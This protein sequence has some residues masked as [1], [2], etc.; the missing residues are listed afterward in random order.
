M[1]SRYSRPKAYVIF[2]DSDKPAPGYPGEEGKEDGVDA[3]IL[4]S[5]TPKIAGN[6]RPR[7]PH[8]TF[9]GAPSLS[10]R[11]LQRQGGGLVQ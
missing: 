6:K 9:Q 10:L 8:V 11:S 4:R 2:Q 5:D 7:V 1:R 3:S